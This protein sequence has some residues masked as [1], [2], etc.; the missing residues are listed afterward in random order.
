M[1]LEKKPDNEP[2]TLNA[3]TPCADGVKIKQH[4]SCVA[5]LPYTW[6]RN[7]AFEARPR[8]AI[9]YVATAVIYGSAV[10]RS[11]SAEIQRQRSST[12]DGEDATLQPSIDN[13]AHEI[14]A[15]LRLKT[16]ANA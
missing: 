12:S 3:A 5:S 10:D 16:R 9:E 15:V 14:D 13:V 11:R 4:A 7:C 2:C 8:P 1:T 6:S